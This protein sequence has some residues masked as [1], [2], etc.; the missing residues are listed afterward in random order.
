MYIDIVADST[1]NTLTFYF[2]P[3]LLQKTGKER[4]LKIFNVSLPTNVKEALRREVDAL[5]TL[6]HPNVVTFLSLETEVCLNTYTQTDL[7]VCREYLK[8][9]FIPYTDC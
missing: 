4:A 5:K 3:I 2:I 8:L 7:C 6:N 9:L 1:T